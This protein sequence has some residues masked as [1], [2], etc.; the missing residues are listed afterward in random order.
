MYLFRPFRM[1]CYGCYVSQAVFFHFIIREPNPAVSVMYHPKSGRE[2]EDFTWI[3]SLRELPERIHSHVYIVWLAVKIFSSLSWNITVSCCQEFKNY[4]IDLLS[5]TMS[6]SSFSRFVCETIFTSS[7][8]FLLA[9][10]TMAANLIFSFPISTLC[11]YANFSLW[12]DVNINFI[13]PY[14]LFSV[15]VVIVLEI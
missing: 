5:C 10:Y 13:H 2:N 3:Y 15:R 12:K 7:G 6:L 1:V 8:I 9:L 14:L 4:F 11:N